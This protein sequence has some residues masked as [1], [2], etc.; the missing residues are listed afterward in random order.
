MIDLIPVQYRMA[1]LAAAF[2][3]SVS[4]AFGAGWTVNGWRLGRDAEEARADRAEGALVSTGEAL[5]RAA[6]LADMLGDYAR[7]GIAREQAII[8]AAKEGQN[9]VKTYV[10]AHG[11]CRFSDDDIEL[12]R[13]NAAARRAAA[14]AAAPD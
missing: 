4:A 5:T 9:V 7:G 3:V 8:N 6:A 13:Q 11:G 14:R 2:A 12:L 1:A 10:A